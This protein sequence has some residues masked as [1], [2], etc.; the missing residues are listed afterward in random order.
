MIRNN[1]DWLKKPLNELATK[2]WEQ[3]CD[4]CGIC[5]IHKIENQDGDYFLT[6]I[7]CKYLNIQTITCRCYHE[8]TKNQTLCKVLTPDNIKNNL[9]WLPETCA[10]RCRFENRSLPYWH[11]LLSK[12]SDSLR[13]A[14]I[15]IRDKVVSESCL[16]EIDWEEHIVDND[17]FYKNI[18]E[19]RGVCTS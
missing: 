17:Y 6:D 2:Q 5:C 12:E 13:K 4:R 14:G 11:P 3:L 9:K 1:A 16:P 7:A 18:K 19:K 15:D 10:Y 8:R